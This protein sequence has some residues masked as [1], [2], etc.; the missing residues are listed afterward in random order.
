MHNGY[1]QA[2]EAW[3]VLR[4]GGELHSD[5]CVEYCKKHVPYLLAVS[6]L[7]REALRDASKV[8]K[9]RDKLQRL[10]QQDLDQAAGKHRRERN[11]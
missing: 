8:R 10:V 11:D 4:V 7:S 9:D 6:E 1:Q 5:A 2:V 3:E